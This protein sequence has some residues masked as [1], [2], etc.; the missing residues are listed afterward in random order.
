MTKY[1]ILL[2]HE[3]AGN[4]P[5]ITKALT[6]WSLALD[7]ANR[8]RTLVSQG[9]LS[10]RAIKRIADTDGVDERAV[11]FSLDR[12]VTQI[13]QDHPEAQS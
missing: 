12:V 9:T 11:K 7:R 4:P 1:D 8:Y 10:W 13:L 5:A 6:D 2:T 3:V